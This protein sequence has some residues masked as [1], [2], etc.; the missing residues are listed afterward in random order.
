MLHLINGSHVWMWELDHKEAWTLKNWC[1]WTVVLEKTLESSLDC[2][3]IKPVH[4]K[5]N[6][7]WNS[8]E[9]LMLMLKLKLKHFGHLMWTT[10]SLEKT[11][12]LGGRR[13][14]G[15]QRVRWLDGITNSMDMNFSR[16]W[17]LVMDKEA[18]RVAVHGFAKNRT[19]RSNRTELNKW[20]V[21]T[22]DG[23]RFEQ[24][25]EAGCKSAVYLDV[26]LKDA[27]LKEMVKSQRGLWVIL[28]GL[29]ICDSLWYNCDS[30]SVTGPW[31][32]LEKYF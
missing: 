24:R 1:F 25:K 22:R 14:R 20:Q 32:N 30:V 13:R 28:T 16:L 29:H 9:R 21:Q 27:S 4:P 7:S 17:E 12:M 8:L 6:Q 26:F 3:E 10:D 31:S 19:Q 15:W 2:K 11:L 5:G 23:K 18:W